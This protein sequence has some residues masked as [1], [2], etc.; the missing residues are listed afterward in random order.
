MKRDF[1]WL[2]LSCVLGVGCSGAEQ[3]PLAK[4]TGTVTC[5]GKPV[6]KAI[7]YFEPLRSGETAVI[8]KQGFALTDES[9]KFTVS[10]YGEND[11][12]V[13][14]RHIVRVGKSETT[15]S[16][17]CALLADEPLMEVDVKSG[18]TNDFPLALRKA[19]RQDR[20]KEADVAKRQ[21]D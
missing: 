6:A 7:V 4:A 1:Y 18:E 10:S 15:P 11:G 12:A 5:D 9:G 13:V 21:E 3:F 2:M 17:D 19:T 8:G 16:C 20:K 14:G